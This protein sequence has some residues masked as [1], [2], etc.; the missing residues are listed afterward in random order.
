[1]KSAFVGE[2]NLNVIKN[3]W[4]NNKKSYAYSN[5]YVNYVKYVNF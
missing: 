2:R 4:Y 1:M 3:A 5:K